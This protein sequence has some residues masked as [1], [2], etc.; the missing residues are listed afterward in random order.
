V[1]PRRWDLA[2]KWRLFRHL[3]KGNDPDAERVYRWHI[4]ARSGERMKRGEPTDKWKR[5]VDDYV[6]YCPILLLSMKSQGFTSVIP[7]DQDGELL[8]GSHRIACAIALDIPVI[9]YVVMRERRIRDPASGKEW[10]PAWGEEWFVKE[11]CPDLE[12]VRSDY[13]DLL[14]A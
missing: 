14:S 12:S 13:A 6:D 4:Q 10:P 7:V 1:T 9:P 2:V 3:I 5:S 11:G 8:D